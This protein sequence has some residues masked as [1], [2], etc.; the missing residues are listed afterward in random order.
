MN[1]QPHR[2]PPNP[3]SDG[4]FVV[5]DKPL[6][7]TSFDVV[8]R[9]RWLLSKALGVKRIKV[10][11]AGTL[12]PLATG[13]VVLCTGKY[14]K[15]IEEVQLMP[16]TY[17]ATLRLGATT[18][19][20][21]L[22]T[23]VDGVYPYEHITSEMIHDAL[24]AFEGPILQSPPLFSA[25][26]V[27][28]TRAYELARKGSDLELPPREVWIYELKL[29]KASLPEIELEVTCGKGTYIRSLARDL[30]QALGSGA[31]L[32]ALRRT[33]VG[34]FGTENGLKPEE[35]QDYIEEILSQTTQED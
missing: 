33:R 16:K 7:W 1:K 10:G 25:V 17:V 4:Q 29:R 15:R 11:H 26:N 23:E 28:G 30:G 5:V 34:D 6:G 27:E 22:E 8:N 24:A 21:D 3:F 14:T 31:H 2:T 13:V 32:T 35:F 18:P 12:D 20:Y 9:F 19:S